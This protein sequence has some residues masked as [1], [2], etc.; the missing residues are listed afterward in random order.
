MHRVIKVGRVYQWLDQGPA[1]ILASCDVE[2]ESIAVDEADD[3]A[4]TYEKGWVISLLQTGEILT[5]HEETLTF[6][7]ERI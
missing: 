4:P 2:G 5:V 6:T 1:I 7:G 3:V